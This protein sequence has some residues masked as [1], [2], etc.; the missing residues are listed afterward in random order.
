MIDKF[1][2]I[3]IDI[4]G[5]LKTDSNGTRSHTIKILNQCRG[6]GAKIVVATGRSYMAAFDY[7]NGFIDIDFLIS[8][9]GALITEKLSQK[10]I[11]SKLLSKKNINM[12][13]AELRNFNVE[14]LL[15]SG[16]DIYVDNVTP[17]TTDYADRNNVDLI[18]VNDLLDLNIPTYRILAVGDK[19]IIKNIEEILK[20]N[21]KRDIYATRSLPNFCEILN[22]EAGKDKS[23]EWICSQMGFSREKVIAF[24]NG[25]ND[26][27]MLTWAGLGV[28][29]RNSEVETL[30]VADLVIDTGVPEY[31][32]SIITKVD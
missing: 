1:N 8:F 24:G 29:M 3:A 13:I 21:Y 16:N 6:L 14:I 31:L 17:W 28:A 5:T 20:T 4:D 9:Q 23:L 2:I 27:E 32:E 25:F 10:K 19:S 11:W 15:Y 18:V 12:A 26:I 7:L 30:A 22:V